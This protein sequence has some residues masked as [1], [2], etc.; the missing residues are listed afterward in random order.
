MVL[1]HLYLIVQCKLLE[2][3][4]ANV[5]GGIFFQIQV[6]RAARR[7]DGHIPAGWFGL[8][9]MSSFEVRLSQQTA[10]NSGK[11]AIG[12]DRL[13]EIWFHCII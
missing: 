4:F 3:S 9:M 8:F 13:N 6:R 7:G 10:W 1:Y 2:I 5:K 12:L 11:Q